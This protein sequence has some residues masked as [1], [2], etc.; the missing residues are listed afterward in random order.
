MSNTDIKIELD[1]KTYDLL[2]AS[3]IRFCSTWR[4]KYNTKGEDDGYNCLLK[5]I[6]IEDGKCRE[7]DPG[8]AG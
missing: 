8:G 5:N 4:C 2:Y 7:Y 6:S 1:R 3:R